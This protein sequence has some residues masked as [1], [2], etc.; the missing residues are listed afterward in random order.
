LSPYFPFP[1]HPASYK[2]DSHSANLVNTSDNTQHPSPAHVNGEM[3]L[4][5]Y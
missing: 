1:S 4:Y 2:L 3:P 5:V